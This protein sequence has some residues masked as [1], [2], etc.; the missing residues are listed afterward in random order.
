ML[1]DPLTSSVLTMDETREMVEDMFK[2][3]KPFLKGFKSI[4]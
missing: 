4:S 3:D 2:I 1:V